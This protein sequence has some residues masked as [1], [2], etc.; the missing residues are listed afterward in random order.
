[1][2]LNPLEHLYQEVDHQL[3]IPNYLYGIPKSQLLLDKLGKT[4]EGI[5]NCEAFSLVFSSP[6][7]IILSSLDNLHAICIQDHKSAHGIAFL[8]TTIKPHMHSLTQDKIWLWWQ[9]NP[10]WD[11]HSIVPSIQ[12]YWLIQLFLP[13]ACNAAGQV[14][15]LRYSRC[16]PH[17]P[18]GFVL[19]DIN[20]HDL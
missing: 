15:L 20:K 5:P 3:N 2:T 17:K 10:T 9:T 6:D 18:S 7:T 11:T 13:L 16:T 1:M 14:Q 12:I 19:L 4:L 8:G